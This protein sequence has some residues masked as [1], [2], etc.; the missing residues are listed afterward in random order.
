MD[1]EDDN[2]SQ[3]DDLWEPVH[4]IYTPA[5]RAAYEEA[6]RVFARNVAEPNIRGRTFTYMGESPSG[7]PM[8]EHLTADNPVNDIVAQADDI[9]ETRI[10]TVPE[11]DPDAMYGINFDAVPEATLTYLGVVTHAIDR[12]GDQRVRFINQHGLNLLCAGGYQV[13]ESV[14]SPFQGINHVSLEAVNPTRAALRATVAP[15]PV[16]VAAPVVDDGVPSIHRAF[17]QAIAGLNIEAIIAAR[18]AQPPCEGPTESETPP[19]PSVK[20]NNWYYTTDKQQWINAARTHL[21]NVLQMDV[22]ISEHRGRVSNPE[23]GRDFV[24]HLHSSPT[25][26]VGPYWSPPAAAWGIR[27]NATDGGIFEISSHG[28]AIFTQEGDEIAAVDPH[29]LWIYPNLAKHSKES[30][31]T[32]FALICQ[33]AV[34]TLLNGV[35]LA[36][37]VGLYRAKYLEV[38]Q[39]RI[40]TTK[41][42][43]E[44]QARLHEANVKNLR[45]Q[46]IESVRQGEV[47]RKLY[48]SI[49][50]G[51]A[52][53]SARYGAEFDAFCR[54]PN[55]ERVLFQ[56]EA[57]IIYT[58]L[59]F[60]TD[61]RT[62]KVHELGKMK[63]RIDQSD[64]EV[65]F[66]NMTRVVTGMNPK[67]HHPHVFGDGHAC[68]G[69]VESA[70]T[71]LI[72]TFE[73]AALAQVLFSFL[74]SVNVDDPAGTEC[75]NWPLAKTAEE[76][77]ADAA[78]E[79][80]K[81]L[82]ALAA[83]QLLAKT[84]RPLPADQV[85]TAPAANATDPDVTLF[86]ENGDEVDA[87]GHVL[88]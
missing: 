3:G 75:A 56:G 83:A 4:R 47:A 50:K 57:F 38:C 53:D 40:E 87:E 5:I 39:A 37:P 26:T 41:K 73:Y 7:E 59:L 25:P 76:Y 2:D 66:T 69:N 43:H 6:R 27:P 8:W 44:E 88:V 14:A 12:F 77:A 62:K 9:P 71:Q 60:F 48:D 86:N 15:T 13:V 32:M 17:A 18:D 65:R 11:T 70:V 19:P 63:I 54:F 45:E 30:D 64:G 68:W 22:A 35:V 20:V 34:K 23:T 84:T 82:D 74:E 49:M 85:V 24:V 81:S 21:A 46:L 28:L 29:N 78:A 36:P 52:G 58:K 79:K 61:P 42:N 55:V 10:L 51:T 72:S 67:M 31:L 80:Q 33:A 1:N 16:A